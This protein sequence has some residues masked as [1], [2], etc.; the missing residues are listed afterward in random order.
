[1]TMSR[2][3]IWLIIA[4]LAALLGV[5]LIYM[6]LQN[7]SEALLMAGFGLFTLGMVISPVIRVLK[8]R[9]KKVQAKEDSAAMRR[10]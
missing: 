8:T 2:E 3:T 4:G 10:A 5:P 9:R 7:E 6:G 1:M